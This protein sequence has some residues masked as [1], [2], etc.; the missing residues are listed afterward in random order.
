M[1]Q[2]ILVSKTGE[3]KIFS[4]GG[5]S[6]LPIDIKNSRLNQGTIKFLEW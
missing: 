4:E 2:Q 6:I 1:K 5:S 3:Q